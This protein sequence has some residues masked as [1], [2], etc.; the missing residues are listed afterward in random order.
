MEAAFG[1]DFSTVT[2]REGEQPAAADA[3]A[4]THG[5]SIT[6]RPGL[7]GTGSADGMRV[8]GH[9]LAHVVQQ[10]AGRVPGTGLTEDPALEA[11]AD[12]AGDRAASGQQ[13]AIASGDGSGAP[14]AAATQPA[15]PFSRL[16]KAI[17][18]K[19]GRSRQQQT[20]EPE[21]EPLPQFGPEPEPEGSYEYGERLPEQPK[22]LQ[23]LNRRAIEQNEAVVRAPDGP[24]R[25]AAEAAYQKT[26]QEIVDEMDN[27]NGRPGYS[28]QQ[29]QAYK[30]V[31]APLIAQDKERARLKAL[32][33][34]A[35]SGEPEYFRTPGVGPHVH[36]PG[37]DP[38]YIQTPAP[39]EYGLKPVFPRR[40]GE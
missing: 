28:R 4:L 32:F 5:E 8:L 23:R 14:P 36:A 19:F 16:K 21:P 6:L 35:E 7:G 40:P 1:A 20:P 12:E 30:R 25:E 10:R 37:T 27:F 31:M 15:G 18:R 38:P 22:F 29:A 26:V 3:L 33:Q 9:E 13:V 39:P 2:V 24:E 34:P 11:E 17:T